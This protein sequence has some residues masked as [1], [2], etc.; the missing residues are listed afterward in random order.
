[1]LRGT[2]YKNLIAFAIDFTA[3]FFAAAASIYLRLGAD[4][5]LQTYQSSLRQ[6]LIFAAIAMLMNSYYKIYRGVWRYFDTYYFIK[7]V[8]S[9]TISVFLFLFIVFL[10]SRL[11]SY[12]RSV[13]FFSWFFL[14]FFTSTPRALYRFYFDKSFTK[15]LN[16]KAI[17]PTP[18]LLVGLGNST[19]N[20]INQLSRMPQANYK[21]VGILD[22]K[23]N[24]GR[25]VHD[26]PI[27][28]TIDNLSKVVSQLDKKN[29]KPARILISHEFYLGGRLK[30]ILKTAESLSIPVSKLPKISEIQH[31]IHASPIQSIPVEDLLRRS[32]RTIDRNAVNQM[33]HNKRVLITGAGGSIGSEIVRQVCAAKPSEVLILDISEYLLYEIQQEVLSSFGGIKLTTRLADIKDKKSIDDLFSHFK[34][35]IVFHAAALKHVPLLEDHKLEAV[36]TNIIGTQIVLN[37]AI[38][39]KVNNFVFISTDKA[40]NPSSFMGATK[41]FAE[42]LCQ[43]VSSKSTKITIVRF[44]NVLASNGSVVPIFEKQISIGGP[45]TVTHPDT[46]RYFMTIKE[47][48]GLVLQATVIQKNSDITVYVLDMGE[49]IKIVD[50]AYHMI[51]L[52]GL[53]PEVDIAIKFIGLRPGEKLHETLFY[54]N[55]DLKKTSNDAIHLANPK[56]IS[57]INLEKNLKQ[58]SVAIRERNLDTITKIIMNV[59]GN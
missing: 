31:N 26:I 42:I 22:E 25:V 36:S 1:M 50:L 4:M 14:I 7:I 11:E 3:A 48:V 30:K 37:A 40:V 43:D 6:S 15:I 12:P 33:V 28:G 39:N 53:K 21:I 18:I 8:K 20:F 13:I 23:I 55:E 58:L 27:L 35:E 47:A 34:P 32:Q 57:H 29:K 46:T 17:K 2:S 44:G 41:R 52:A 38:K 59:V 16:Y 56:C 10:E 9:S 45:I 19:D 54:E 24:I 5:F 49:P 51:R